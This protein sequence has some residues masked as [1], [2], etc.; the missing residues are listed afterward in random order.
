VDARIRVSIVTPFLNARRFL[1]E[2]I[3]SV[4]AQTYDR[5]ELLLVDDGS[6]DDSA[7]IAQRYTAAHPHKVRHLAHAGRLN[8]G[9]SASRNLGI[10]HATGE[11]LAFLDADDVYLPRKLE[12]QVPLLDAH[13]R[14]GMLYA[15][16]EYWYSWSGRADD[17]ARDCVWRT[18]G[19]EP[20]RLI[21]PPRMLVTFLQ[22]GGTVPCIGSVLARREAV[23][24]VGAW[25]ESFRYICTDQAFHAKLCLTFPVFI[26][27]GCWDRYRQHEDSSCHTVARAGQSDLAFET[28]LTWLESYLTRATVVDPA[29]WCALRKALRP[30][31]HPLLHRLERRAVHHTL[32]VKDVLTRV[33]R[34]AL[35]RLVRRRLRAAWTR[36][37]V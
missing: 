15:A 24:S 20:N 7:S 19:V 13:P 6:T 25:E 1:A 4:L 17:A 28:Y 10:R 32:R 2:A 18:Y 21:E 30:Y 16:T 14:A 9:A 12:Q 5:W 34:S 36:P 8:M 37:L 23:Q 3:E 26:A 22:D 31:R 27:D 11:Y 33:G 29:V 35:P